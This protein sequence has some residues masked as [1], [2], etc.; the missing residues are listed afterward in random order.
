M[1]RISTVL[2]VAALSLMAGSYVGF[3]AQAPD[4]A[5]RPPRPQPPARMPMSFF[6]TGEWTLYR[7][8]APITP[9]TT[10]NFGMTIAFPKFQKW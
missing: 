9:Q 2:A 1:K 4:G 8:F 10:V 6:V 5:A 7:Q 3:A